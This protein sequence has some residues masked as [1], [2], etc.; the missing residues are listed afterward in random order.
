MAQ[1]P[2]RADGWG[3]AAGGSVRAFDWRNVAR[4]HLDLFEELVAIKR[5]PAMHYRTDGAT[6]GPT[7]T[8]VGWAD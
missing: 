4:R 6:A 5:R 7:T 3:Q 1:D 8:V 2:Q